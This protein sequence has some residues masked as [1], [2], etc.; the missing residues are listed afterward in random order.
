MWLGTKLLKFSI[1]T[2]LK[3]YILFLHICLC[4]SLS[5]VNSLSTK[6]SL[7]FSVLHNTF[8][9]W[10]FLILSIKCL[11]CSILHPWIIKLI[12]WTNWSLLNIKQTKAVKMCQKLQVIRVI[13]QFYKSNLFSLFCFKVHVGN[14]SKL[15]WFLF[16]TLLSG[17]A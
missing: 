16:W 2:G 7:F 11:N 17:G 6:I 1:S 10:A 15:L 12:K 8:F 5:I 13:L 9:P 3:D 4:N 14:V